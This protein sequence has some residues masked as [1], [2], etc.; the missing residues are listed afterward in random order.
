MDQVR[1]MPMADGGEG[2]V[3]AVATARPRDER[4]RTTVTGPDGRAVDAEWLMLEDD[5]GPR[6][7][8]VELAEASG[9]LRLSS[10]APLTAHTIGLGEVMAAAIAA[11]AQRLLIALGGSGSTDGGAGALRGLGAAI[12]DGN[13][14]DVPSGTAGLSKIARV[15]LRSMVAV[16]AGGALLLSDVD[17]PLLGPSGAVAVF[18]P[19]KGLDESLAPQAERALTHW[20]EVLADAG[21]PVPT[22]TPGAGAA[23]GTAFGLLAWGASLTS[24]AQAIAEL[25]GLPAALAAADIVIT[26]EGR[27]DGQSGRGKAPVEV[28]RLAAQAGVPCALVAGA[29]DAPT[30]GFIAA[31]ALTDLAGSPDAAMTDPLP[32]LRR[33]GALLADLPR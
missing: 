31:H 27:F 14:R 23:G 19:Q 3:D 22:D 1:L 25:I 13:G 30:T 12:V 26:G 18:G 24:G 15:D 8:V 32:Y 10:P 4:R 29:I 28:A 11:G 9:L 21:R 5:G 7:A 17:N 16:P 20:A 2:T 33:A 6:T